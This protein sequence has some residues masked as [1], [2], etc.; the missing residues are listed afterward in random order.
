MRLYKIIS[1]SVAILLITVFFASVV[2]VPAA[3][4]SAQLT[5]FT[6]N[7]NPAVGK[8]VTFTATLKSGNTLLSSK[9][10]TIYHY[11]NGV[12]YNDVTKA[13]TNGQITLTQS[14]SS[15]GQ[16]TYYATFAGDSTYRP[17]R[18]AS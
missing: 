17:Q 11:F 8:S 9:S 3:A 13:T 16:R 4:Q 18:A 15:T 12:R 6:S 7:P 2:A 14:F 10:V 5:L 1:F